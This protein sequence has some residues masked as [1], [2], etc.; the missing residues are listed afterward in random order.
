[1]CIVFVLDGIFR[2]E[3][4]SNTNTI[5]IY[6]SFSGRNILA[7]IF[8][9]YNHNTHSLFIFLPEFFGRN[10]PFNTNTIHIFV[11]VSVLHL[12]SG[13]N[14][15]AGIYLQYKYNKHSLCLSCIY[16]SAGIF[17]PE[18]SSNTNTMHIILLF[19]CLCC[20]YS[21][22]GIF[23][24]IEIQYKC[25]VVTFEL[26]L[27]PGRKIPLNTNTIHTYFLLCLRCFDFTAG[28]FRQIQIQY[29]FLFI[30][31][32]EFSVKYNN[33]THILLLYLRCFDFPA[34]NFR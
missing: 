21:P 32:P 2:T 15:P 6:C 28:N 10:I 9:Q 1:M 29:T 5:H 24:Q 3:Y 8:L 30:F 23:R 11:V 14:F 25:I 31:R 20:I 22:A 34:G 16:F 13:R 4:F 7:G 26:H 18:Y 17:R 12:F 19:T 33:N 27:Y